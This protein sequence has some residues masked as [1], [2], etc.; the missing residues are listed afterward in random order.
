M[1]TIFILARQAT[2]SALLLVC[3]AVAQQT[4]STAVSTNAVE[5]AEAPQSEADYRN[6]V[7]FGFGSTFIDGDKAAFMQ[8][9]GIR[10]DA[11]GGIEDLHFE[12]DVGKRGL[13]TLDGRAIYDNHDYALRLDLSYPDLGYVRAGYREFRTWYDGSGG[14]FPPTDLWFSIFDEQLA[15]DRKELFFE[16]GLYLVLFASSAGGV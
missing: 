5:A 8:R 16:A 15:I 3:P 10:R 11:F 13:F 1:N 7:E 9:T 14:F 6:W 2:L 12:Q 4:N